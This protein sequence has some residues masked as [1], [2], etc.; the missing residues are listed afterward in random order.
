MGQIVVKEMVGTRTFSV[1]PSSRSRKEHEPLMILA[2]LRY[3]IYIR[4]R[5]AT[6]IIKKRSGINVFVHNAAVGISS[7]KD[8]TG[9]KKVTHHLVPHVVPC[10]ICAA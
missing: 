7:S 6:R 2:L 1:V 8:H 4:G 10:R 3:V 5:D 9:M